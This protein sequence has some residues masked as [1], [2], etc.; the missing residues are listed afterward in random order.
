M[1]YEVG[2]Y[3]LHS[4]GFIVRRVREVGK[5]SYVMSSLWW[6]ISNYEYGMI[7]NFQWKDFY[8]KRALTHSEIEN[9]IN[10]IYPYPSDTNLKLPEIFKLA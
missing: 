8:V 5:G 2:D 6:D 1:K 7:E 10:K 3:L 9:I 4:G